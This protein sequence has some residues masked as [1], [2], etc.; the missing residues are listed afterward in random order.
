DARRAP[1]SFPTRRSSDLRPP[2][3]PKR[4]L[5]AGQP[6]TIRSI[7]KS[8]CGNAFGWYHWG[9]QEAQ[10]YCG[11]TGS[12]LAVVAL[13]ELTHAIHHLRSE[14]HTSELQSL[15]HLVC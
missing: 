15:R 9:K 8:E 2:P 10:L 12:N 3:M 4:I 1:P 7:G 13:H 14:E 5:V 6:V 11:L